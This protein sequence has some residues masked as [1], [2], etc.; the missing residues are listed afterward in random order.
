[1]D[2][3]NV[4]SLLSDKWF[5]NQS[6]GQAL[7]PTLF[8]I[9]SGNKISIEKTKTPEAFI[10]SENKSIVASNFDSSNNNEDYVLIVS[11]KNPITKYNQYC[12][13]EGTKSKQQTMA[14]YEGDPKCKGVVLDIDSGG[15]QV[16]GTPEFHD[17]IKN[18]SKPVVAYTDG[19]MCS[20]AY[21]L[22]SAASYIV[23]NKRAD[24]IGSIGT[25]ISFVDMTGFYEKKGAKVITEYATKST[26]KNKD[27][28]DL[29]KGDP[30]G[31]IKNELDPIT[32]TFHD[33][34]K[35]ARKNLNEEVLTGGT[36]NAKKSITNGLIDEIGTMKTAIEK[37]FSLAK[38]KKSNT[39][40]SNQNMKEIKAPSIQ[41]ALG[42]ETP[43]QATDE[44]VFMQESE[45]NT[46]ETALTS[47]TAN[48]TTLQANLDTVN[49]TVTDTATVIDAALD[50]AEIEHTP[51]M[52]LSEK[53]T[54]LNNQRNEFAKKPSKQNTAAIS[55]GDD[56]PD[57]AP[58]KKVYAHNEYAKQLLNQ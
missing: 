29:L 35:A 17:F 18:Y 54:L 53:I 14:S 57:G 4:H 12:G 42:Y 22:G 55:D 24:A 39:Q 16:S 9:L 27:F 11:L 50:N 46:L 48:A 45:I 3:S 34:V 51:E 20:A 58:I 32:D 8:S 49:T 10:S 37:V 38:T 47:A 31:Y 6:Y 26:E 28:E 13:P 5:I 44:G 43:F 30:T 19:L 40:N 25:M 41:N 56:A 23:A 15:G 7:M 2:I 1:M 33:D 52:S 36:Y 21:Y